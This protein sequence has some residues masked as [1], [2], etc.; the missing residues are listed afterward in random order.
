MPNPQPGHFSMARVVA[1]ALV[2][3]VIFFR[4]VARVTSGARFLLDRSNV[5]AC[6]VL[7]VD[8]LGV[9]RTRPNREWFSNR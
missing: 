8:A 3:G 5:L 6:V 4:V 7:P 1:T 2:P 9:P